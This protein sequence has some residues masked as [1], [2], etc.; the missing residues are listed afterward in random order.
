MF[1]NKIDLSIISVA[2]PNDFKFLIESYSLIDTYNSDLNLKFYII[3][4]DIKS[5]FY[6]Y[7]KINK[8]IPNLEIIPKFLIELNNFNYINKGSI[9]HGITL[10]LFFQNYKIT[11]KY[12]LIID[13][14]FFIIQKNWI[15]NVLKYCDINNYILFGSTWHPKWIN[16]YFDFPSIHFLLVNINQL[17]ICDFDFAPIPQ[18]K[19]NFSKSSL[20][21]SK[22]IRFVY[23]FFYFRFK[24]NNGNDT[25][26][27][28]YQKYKNS[29][30]YSTLKPYVGTNDFR[31]IPHLITKIGFSFEK[32][33]KGKRFS[34]LPENFANYDEIDSDILQLIFNNQI[35]VFN[36]N[37]QIFA[38][39]LRK[40]LKKNQTQEL[41]L[42]FEKLLNLLK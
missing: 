32:K 7:E 35:E 23:Y 29:I 8:K 12:C 16:K 13:P 42:L 37:G 40:F 28:I 36:F 3:D 19:G 31:Q 4:N 34:Y 26:I 2:G 14:D 10:N 1:N 38:F 33:I 20:S 11:S 17:N 27:K 5:N 30:K 15:K 6:L 41:I 24:K 25:G 18:L 21:K 9:E 39:H 22:I